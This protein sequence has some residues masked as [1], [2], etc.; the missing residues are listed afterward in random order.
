M[1]QNLQNPQNNYICKVANRLL[2]YAFFECINNY[3]I[4]TTTR[5]RVVAMQNVLGFE[6]FVGFVII[7]MP[8]LPHGFSPNAHHPSWRPSP[9]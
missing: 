2:Y 8:L 1:S 4:A 6:G 5:L 7:T 3:G 9:R